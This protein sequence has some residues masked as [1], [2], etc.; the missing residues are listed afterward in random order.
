MRQIE[1]FRESLS[2]QA[3]TGVEIPI[4]QHKQRQDKKP[5]HPI[6]QAESDSDSTEDYLYTVLTPKKSPTVR[7]TVNKHCFDATLDTGASLNVIDRATYEKMDGVKL[8]TTT[9]KTF[10]YNAQTPIKFLGKFEA[11]IA[12]HFLRIRQWGGHLQKGTILYQ[13]WRSDRWLL[14][15]KSLV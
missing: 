7:V 1:S 4:H 12:G 6:H 11:L 9:V 5:I 8:K 15:T 2:W 13:V 14:V 3:T 10:A